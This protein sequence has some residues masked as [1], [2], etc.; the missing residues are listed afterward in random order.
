MKTTDPSTQGTSAES[1]CTDN[2]RS[3]IINSEN[4]SPKNM[5][6]LSTDCSIDSEQES[7]AVVKK[8]VLPKRLIALML[9][10]TITSISGLVAKQGVL[11]CLLTLLMVLA[12]FG[13]QRTALYLLRAY[14]FIQLVIVCLLPAFFYD[15]GNLVAGP[16]SFALGPLTITL[17]DWIIFSLLIVFAGAQVWVS[18]NAKVKAWF[19]P[20]INLNIMS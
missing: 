20:K 13:R 18:L 2:M 16:T 5:S 4:I 11:F 19:K 17:P 14:T 15:P 10:F 7:S 12:V 8:T 6:T 9:F 1:T 3:E